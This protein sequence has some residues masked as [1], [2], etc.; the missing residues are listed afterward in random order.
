MICY[1]VLTLSEERLLKQQMP[2]ILSFSKVY[3]NAYKRESKTKDPLA[4]QFNTAKMHLGVG[5]LTS[6]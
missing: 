1:R 3:G 5:I 4:V 6:S 2:V